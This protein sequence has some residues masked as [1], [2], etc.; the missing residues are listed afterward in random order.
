MHGCY[1]LFTQLTTF[2]SVFASVYMYTFMGNDHLPAQ[3]LW[4]CT[5]S[6][7]SAW[8][9]TYLSLVL[10]VKPELRRSFWSTETIV[11]YAHAVFH[12]NED[13]EHRMA[14]F[15]FQQCKWESSRD[16]VREFTHSKWAGWKAEKPAWFTEEIIARVPD[17]FI[18]VAEV[19]ALNA[20]HGGKRRRS[21]VG[22]AGSVRQSARAS[23]RESARKSSLREMR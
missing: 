23:A 6:V 11:Q 2:A 9:L 17:E 21:S 16:E 13:D 19:A 18:P 7:F 5:G 14:I 20:A 10:M 12:D 4:I 3:M 1:F 8:A 22:L 15:D